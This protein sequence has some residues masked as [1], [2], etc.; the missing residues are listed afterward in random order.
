MQTT[1]A[2]G[3]RGPEVRALQRALIRLGYDLGPSQA[4]G[5]FGRLTEAAVRSVRARNG[6]PP[7]PAVVPP[8]LFSVLVAEIDPEMGAGGDGVLGLRLVQ[9]RRYTPGRSG[10]LRYLC[11]HVAEIAEVLRAAENLQGWA[12]GPNS[13]HASWGYAVDADSETWSVRDADT[14]WHAPGL[15][16]VSIGVELAGSSAQSVAQ[17]ADPYSAAML[18]RAARLYAALMTKHGIPLRF[19]AAAELRNAAVAGWPETS[20]GIT[21]HLE[22]TR[23][24]LDEVLP[25]VNRS[26]HTDP[27]PNFPWPVFFRLI[28]GV[29]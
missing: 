13:P 12:G 22:V 2:R 17:W 19:V 15:N 29:L 21:S 6:L 4:D 18:A 8:S 11:T 25:G 3:S 27:G 5:D 20:T 14:A 16:P 9:A 10:P 1:F 23:A 24:R 26:T 28:E 7:T